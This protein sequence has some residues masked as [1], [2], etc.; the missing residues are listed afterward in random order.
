MFSA[1]LAVPIAIAFF[2]PF[3]S[4]KPFPFPSS[5]PNPTVIPTPSI[6]PSP[7]PSPVISPT[8]APSISSAVEIDDVD[9]S[10]ANFMDEFVITGFNFGS[11]TGNVNFRQSNQGFPSGGS[12]IISWS[13]T[14][15]KAKVPGL[16]KGYYRI[17]L[18]T[19]DGKKSNEVKFTIKNGQPV[20]N[21]T[22][23][24]FINGE[25][26]LIFQGSEFGR[27]GE[28]NIYLGS[29]IIAKGIIKYWS[30]SRVRFELPSLVHAEYG[31]QIQTADGRQSSLKYFTVGN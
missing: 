28:V 21:S 18:I 11:D 10:S 2:N 1:L 16:K 13:D 15:V 24:S 31:F 17:Q 8:P 12:P 20:I 26:E 30:S 19:S 6:I 5:F 23:V 3:P 9:P 27:R 4:F 7:T 25:Y 29:D 22:S 14:E